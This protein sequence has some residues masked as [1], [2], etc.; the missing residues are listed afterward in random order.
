MGKVLHPL[1]VVEKALITEKGALLVSQNKYL[2]RVH[3]W[4]NKVAVKAAVEESFN[5]KVVAVNVMN[6]KGKPRRSRNGRFSH[7]MDWKKAVVTLAEG[8]K[9]ELFEGV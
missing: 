9:L 3:S 5:V 8:D 1:Q 4:A 6:M 2:F 7:E